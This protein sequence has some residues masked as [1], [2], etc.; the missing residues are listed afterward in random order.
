MSADPDLAGTVDI[1]AAGRRQWDVLVIGAGPAGALAAREAARAGFATLLV[2]RQAFPRDKVCGGCLNHTAVSALQRAGLGDRLAMCRGEAITSVRLHHEGRCATIAV[3]P[4]VAISR[5][6]FDAMLVKAAVAAGAQFLPEAS[7]LLAGLPPGSAVPDCRRLELQHRRDGS[8]G[9]EARVVVAADGLSQTSLQASREF[10]SRVARSAR[11]GLGGNGAAGTLSLSPG[12]ITM[13]I[14]RAGYV[15]AVMTE[16]KRLNLAAALDPDFVK[17]CGSPAASVATVLEEAGVSRHGSLDVA[18]WQ[19]TLPL[20]RRTPRP[21]G[22]RVLVI[23]DAA[24]YV[25]PFTGEGMAWAIAAAVAAVP[26]IRQGVSRWDVSLEDAW[27]ARYR[28][29]VLGQQRRC[30]LI[31]RSLRS[32]LIVRTVV[33]LLE[34]WPSLARPIVMRLGALETGRSE[35]LL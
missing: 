17:R 19:G 32:P 8:V 6:T 30:T 3:P 29:I 26:F 24:G 20:M 27:I 2:E 7:A 18:T 28:A 31:A 9:I 23:G 5:R 33:G 16:G 11:I 1:Q 13:A 4:G 25:E 21:A 34:R 14:G 12:A 22:H 10:Q 35:D 15:G